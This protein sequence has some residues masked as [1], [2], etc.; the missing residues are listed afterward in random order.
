MLC[1]LI[2]LVLLNIL[3]IFFLSL[4]TDNN[5]VLNIYDADCERELF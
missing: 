1:K 4:T 5:L 3:Y 2:R